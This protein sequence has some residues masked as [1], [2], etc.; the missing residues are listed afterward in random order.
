[1]KAAMAHINHDARNDA[2]TDLQKSTMSTSMVKRI[3][4]WQEKM[5]S[6]RHFPP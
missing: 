3:S 5:T 2:D 1:M 4:P 6:R